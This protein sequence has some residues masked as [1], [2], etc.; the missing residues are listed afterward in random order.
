V[1]LIRFFKCMN[2]CLSLLHSD[3]CVGWLKRLLTHLAQNAVYASH[4]AVHNKSAATI[5]SIPNNDHLNT[6][7]VLEGA[8]C[9]CLN[10][11]LSSSCAFM[12]LGKESGTIFGEAD[13]N[14]LH[15]KDVHEFKDNFVVDDDAFPNVYDDDQDVSESDNE[16]YQADHSVLDMYGKRFNLRSNPLDLERFSREEKLRIDLLQLL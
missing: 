13:N 8:T 7:H 10:V 3:H 12:L 6:S 15:V 11:N 5:L 1:R 2:N 14:E 9:S 4:D 16:D